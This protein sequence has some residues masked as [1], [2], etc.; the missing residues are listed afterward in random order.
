MRRNEDLRLKKTIAKNVRCHVFVNGLTMHDMALKAH[1]AP[2]TLYSRMQCATDWKLGE[3][4]R[5]AD[6]FGVTV[7][8]L[9]KEVQL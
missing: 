4:M 6:A 1:I 8:D 2:S 7:P 5:I 3:L 9:M